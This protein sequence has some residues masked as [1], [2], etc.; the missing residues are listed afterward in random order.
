MTLDEL[1]RRARVAPEQLREWIGL[2]LI[3]HADGDFGRDALERARLLRLATARGLRAAAVADLS[4]REGDILGRFVELAPEG[5]DDVVDAEEAA[6][7][8]GLDPAFVRR[9]LAEAGLPADLGTEDSASM[10]AVRAA[11]DAGLPE[12]AL[13]QLVRVY[14]D[15]LGRVADAEVRLFH[16]YVHEPL[17]AAG[18]SPADVAAATDQASD[19]LLDLVEPTILYFHRKAWRRAAQ[20]DALHHL[21]DDVGRHGAVGELPVAVLF[22]DLASFTPMTEAMG[23]EAAAEVLDRFSALVRAEATH[24]DGRVVKQIGDEFMIV[25]PNA[26]AAVRYA[27]HL[28]STTEAEPSFPALRMGAHAGSALYREADYLGAT[29]NIAARVA[30]QAE[31]GQLLVT[32]AVRDAAGDAGAAWASLGERRLKGLAEPIGLFAAVSPAQPSARRDPVCGMN[33]DPGHGSVVPSSRADD[34]FFCS[35]GCRERFDAE[36]GRYQRA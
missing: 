23:D 33:V 29:V 28:Q 15:A 25:F 32:A 14:A 34:V 1:A 18:A 24:C 4:A 10:R 20:E 11:L 12:A 22:V 21:A 19:A 31:P 5:P 26:A 8:A 3:D 35:E 17:R 2:G 6:R 9:L 16:F 30:G 27:L 7:E 13:L 36:P